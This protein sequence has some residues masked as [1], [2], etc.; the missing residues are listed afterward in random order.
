[1]DGVYK[2]MRIVDQYQYLV[3]PKDEK[4]KTWIWFVLNKSTDYVLGT[5]KWYSQWRQYCF[6][7]SADTV[8][9]VKCLVDIQDFIQKA[10][11]QWRASRGK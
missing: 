10:M 5:I 8:F 9:N 3:N 4:S 1:M 11:A 6:F 7:P 2:Y